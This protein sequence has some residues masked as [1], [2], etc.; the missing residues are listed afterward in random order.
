MTGLD[1]LQSAQF[2]TLNGKRMV[3]LDGD[4]YEALIEWLETLED[5][6]IVRQALADLKAAGG[7]RQKAGW[8]RWD[9]VDGQ[10]K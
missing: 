6:S 7:D 3:V 5:A 10:L 2:V 8:L 4:D 9:E 1:A